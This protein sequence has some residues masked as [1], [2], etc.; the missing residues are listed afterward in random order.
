VARRGTSCSTLLWPSA[1]RFHHGRLPGPFLREVETLFA[2]GVLRVTV[3]SPPWRRLNLN[4]AV[5]LIPNLYRAGTLITG[6]S[7]PT[8]LAAPGAH[9]W[10]SKDS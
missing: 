3:A 4:A 8:L 10:I 9:S 5:L 6:E 1:L 7:L 2:A